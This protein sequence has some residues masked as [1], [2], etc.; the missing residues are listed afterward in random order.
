MNNI[1]RLIAII[2]LF[3]CVSI[4]S[5]RYD[6]AEMETFLLSNLSPADAADRD[7]AFYRTYAIEPAMRAINEMRWGD[8]VPE[9]LFKYFVLPL[10]I[11][12]E[13]LDTHRVSFYEELKPIVE[14]LSMKDAILA[15]NHWCHSKVTYQPSDGRTHSPLQSVSSA[16][17][18]CGE[19]STF[20][21]AAL[22]TMGIPARQVY[23]PRWA[24]TDDNHAWV[25]AWADGQWW[26]LG[27]CEPEPILNLGWFNEPAARGMLMHA[28]VFGNYQGTE[29]TISKTAAH[30]DLN[31]TDHYAPVRNVKVRVLNTKGQPL[32]HAKVS[33]RIYN[34]AEFYPLAIKYTDSE[35]IA[36]LQCGLGTL[37]IW[38][39][40]GLN[41]KYA[42]LSPDQLPD[43]TITLT[44]PR[45]NEVAADIDIIAP[46]AIKSGSNVS[47]AARKEND[48][49]CAREDSIRTA[50]TST[51]IGQAE[52]GRVAKKNGID[53]IAT[54]EILRLSRG[55]HSTITK[56][57]ET[58]PDSL[59]D[60]SIR[61][62][63]SLSDK[64]LT[65]VT[66][67]VLID[68]L[69]AP[70]D[71]SM[72]QAQY[73]MSPRIE[74][75]AITPY[76]NKLSKLFTKNESKQFCENP[77]LLIQWVNDNIIDTLS[78]YPDQVTMSPVAVATHRATSTRSRNIFFVA[79]AR[80][81]G[82]PA[83]IDPVTMVPQWA[84]TGKVWH[85]VIFNK[86]VQTSPLTH[87]HT[88]SISY[89]ATPNISD[90]QYYAHFT[91]SKIVGGEPQLL[92]YPDF[93]PLSQL[94]QEDLTLEE[95][96]YMITTGQR[97]ANGNVLAHTEIF[98]LTKD[99]T[100]NL[101]IRQ[102]STQVQVL[103]QFDAENKYLPLHSLSPKSILSTTGRGYYILGVL[104]ANHEPS[105]HAL[106]DIVLIKDQ[107]EKTGI[108]ILIIYDSRIPDNIFDA[109]GNTL[110]ANTHIGIDSEM[111]VNSL[112]DTFGIAASDLPIFIIADTFNRVVFFTNGYNIGL[113]QKLL[114]TI[115][116]L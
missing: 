69:S 73:I 36:E 11:N 59:L 50:Y 39:T 53:S 71:T 4:Y 88:L 72:W 6:A 15:I 79:L 8:S 92:N 30:T 26:F 83:R 22:R 52:S 103:G 51:F 40:D 95:G 112:A 106:R 20:T 107:L 56:L 37:M 10:R 85:D 74:Y 98:D 16:I 23:T 101:N 55:N 104:K 75:E 76:R 57:W 29:T 42:I 81:L 65:D 2:F 90:P 99:M 33:F 31:L 66:M 27:A 84:D 70:V 17:G 44:E 80:S 12:N 7:T 97:L 93:A 61:L 63:R 86:D 49:L 32:N 19:E 25:E 58:L 62:L 67:D 64:D 18:R 89:Q 54:A 77:N 96:I 111:V 34:Y 91:I 108:P 14:N 35:G 45:L 47:E 38:A 114:D 5:Q 9:E 116:K 94:T 48:M 24:H 113:G 1:H 28:R 68:H 82:I 21:V 3:A 115:H 43:I 13:M 105:N 78:W 87:K 46:V 60:K 100:I 110:P 109:I 102:D 41:Y